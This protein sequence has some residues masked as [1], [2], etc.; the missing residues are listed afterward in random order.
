[1]ANAKKKRG[2][3]LAGD[4]FEIPLGGNKVGY[5]RAL[6][7]EQFG[8]IFEI[9]N[10]TG[11]ALKKEDDFSKI[12]LSRK[13][14]AYINEEVPKCDWRFLGNFPV[15]EKSIQY[16]PFFYGSSTSSWTVT[17]PHRADKYFSAK[18]YTYDDMLRLGYSHLVLWLNDSIIKHVRDNKPL[19]WE[20]EEVL[21][22]D[23]VGR[24]W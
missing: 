1:V 12:A 24:G 13:S 4:A 15:H 7:R 18:E 9:Y 23:T 21:S 20:S 14:V 5:C 22:N 19:R 17:E 3:I 16:P 10:E 11:E 2:K 6:V 8:V